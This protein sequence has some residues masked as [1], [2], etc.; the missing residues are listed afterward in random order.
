MFL[1]V[2]LK[3]TNVYRKPRDRSSQANNTHGSGLL[4]P[5]S[6]NAFTASVNN[7]DRVT[8]SVALRLD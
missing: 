1:L 8:C 4:R 2:T 7:K 3:A 6:S 5:V